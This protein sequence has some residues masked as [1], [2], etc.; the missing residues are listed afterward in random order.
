MTRQETGAGGADIWVIDWQRG[1]VPTPLTRDPADAINPVW[2]PDS[3][4]I[5]Y[6]TYRKGNADVY[7]R[8]A[9]GVGPETPLI[10]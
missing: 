9:N 8:N 10:E 1:G 4:R 6:T 3:R 2:S 5:A 7:V